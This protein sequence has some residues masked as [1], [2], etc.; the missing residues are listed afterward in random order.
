MVVDPPRFIMPPLF[1]LL[2]EVLAL[3]QPVAAS[4][5]AAS[6]TKT[7]IMTRF[8]RIRAPS[9]EEF[10]PGQGPKARAAVPVAH[11]TSASSGWRKR[12]ADIALAVH[13]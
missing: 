1:V 11:R 10:V 13:R 12:Y 7:T 2:P 6:H 4:A 9:D 5:I 3:E 8:W